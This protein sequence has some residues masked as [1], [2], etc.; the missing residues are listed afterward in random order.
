MTMSVDLQSNSIIVTAPSQLANEVE[1]LAR[2]I[3]REGRQS[4]QVIP[5]NGL[6]TLQIQESLR[7]LFG[8]QIR[9]I[10]ANPNVQRTGNSQK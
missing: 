2:A 10:T 9:Q 1:T 5:L 8:D 7:S 3:D 4:V 6:N